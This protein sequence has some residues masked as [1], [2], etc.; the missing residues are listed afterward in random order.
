MHLEN[1]TANTNTDL[2]SKYKL[3]LHGGQTLL[4]DLDAAP[5]DLLARW[6]RRASS[7]RSGVRLGLRRRRR[8]GRDGQRA[9]FERVEDALGVLGVAD[10]PAS[11]PA[12]DGG[13]RDVHHVLASHQFLQASGERRADAPRR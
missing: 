2:P 11:I 6:L 10:E 13:L 8:L 12:P 1:S 3:T 5:C 7:W 9:V 4:R